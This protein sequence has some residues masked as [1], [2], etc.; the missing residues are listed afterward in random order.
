MVG[1]SSD[2]NFKVFLQTRNTKELVC[3]LLALNSGFLPFNWVDLI[4]GSDDEGPSNGV[5]SHNSSSTTSSNDDHSK[6]RDRDASNVTCY[7]FGSVG[8]VSV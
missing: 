3:I 2:N 7:R 8:Q 6:R 4:S 1:E 5:V